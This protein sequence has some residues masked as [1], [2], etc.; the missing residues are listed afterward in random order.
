MQLENCIKLSCVIVRMAGKSF[1]LAFNTKDRPEK[2]ET[3]LESRSSVGKGRR[4]N[5]KC[6]AE[7]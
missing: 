6:S 3:S 1:F 2:N 4:S 5:L 7:S